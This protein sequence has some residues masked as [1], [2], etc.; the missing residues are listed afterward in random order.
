MANEFKENLKNAVKLQRRPM[1]EGN[2]KRSRKA[3]SKTWLYPHAIER[4]Y[5]K[6]IVSDIVNPLRKI[7]EPAL[8][9]N[10]PRWLEEAGRFDSSGMDDFINSL[11]IEMNRDFMTERIRQIKLDEYRTDEYRVDTWVEEFQILIQRLIDE[12]ESI[13]TGPGGAAAGST[14]AEL[15]SEIADG[16]F[17]FNR[18]QWAKTTTATAGFEFRT[19]EVWYDAVKEAWGSENYRLLKNLDDDYINR[20]N[21]AVMRGVRDQSSTAE[22]M[23]DVRKIGKNISTARAKLIAEDQVGKLNGVLTKRRQLEA[24]IPIYIWSTAKDERVRGK[25]GGKYPRAVPSHWD[26]E[27]KLC[28]WDDNTV[29]ADPAVAVER[30]EKGNIVNINWRS[31]TGRMPFAIPGQE[32]RCRCTANAYWESF[33]QEVDVELSTENQIV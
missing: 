2:R 19:P 9:L 4:K 17:L 14:A 23:R 27:G 18:R 7:A 30:D 26:M 10:L 20:I 16:V 1:N 29:F 15:I 3:K 31:R 33:L 6:G 25:P 28:R 5:W 32:I 11:Q 22:I 13:F 21:E 24:G 8:R 12:Q